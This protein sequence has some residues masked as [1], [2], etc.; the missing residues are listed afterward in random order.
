VT[1]VT[2]N[3][4]SFFI[5]EEPTEMLNFLLQ[6]MCLF[7]NLSS[8]NNV[9]YRPV[10]NVRSAKCSRDGI[11]PPRQEFSFY[12]LKVLS[13]LRKL[14][15]RGD[16]CLILLFRGKCFNLFSFVIL[17]STLLSL[18]RCRN[19]SQSAMLSLCNEISL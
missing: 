7:L 5:K 4:S 12:F 9:T 16:H 14:S 17:Q 18:Y 6:M 19:Y 3:Y 8:Q 13:S 2:F 11:N 15:S 10:E 1:S